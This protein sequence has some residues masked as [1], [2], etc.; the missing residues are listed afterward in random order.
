MIQFIHN[1][2]NI[3]LYKYLNNLEKKKNQKSININ[4]LVIGGDS[5]KSYLPFRVVKLMASTIPHTF[6][7]SVFSTKELSKQEAESSCVHNLRALMV[8]FSGTYKADIIYKRLLLTT[9]TELSVDLTEEKKWDYYVYNLFSGDAINKLKNMIP[10]DLYTDDYM[11][12]KLRESLSS[13]YQ[14]FF[15][16]LDSFLDKCYQ[17]PES[18]EQEKQIITNLEKEWSK[19][20]YNFNHATLQRLWATIVAKSPFVNKAISYIY[21]IVVGA[22]NI[23]IKPLMVYHAFAIEQYFSGS[24]NSVCYRVYQTW[25]NHMTLSNYFSKMG[26]GELDEGTLTQKEISYF[27]NDFGKILSGDSTLKLRERCFGTANAE[28]PIKILHFDISKKILLGISLRFLA[29]QINPSDC[30]QNFKSVLKV[31]KVEDTF[32]LT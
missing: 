32:S 9:I 5:N 29:Y 13:S 31:H 20:D 11:N 18:K 30:L 8:I 17:V 6:V 15:D 28:M 21:Y 3:S 27:L 2:S 24:K 16:H 14:R 1:N 25:R 12:S 22:P 7:Q 19:L 23:H 26:Y 4:T 10:D